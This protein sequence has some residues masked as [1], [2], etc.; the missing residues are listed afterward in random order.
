MCKNVN[1]K[2]Q[3]KLARL[4]LCHNNFIQFHVTLINTFIR[5]YIVLLL[6]RSS[7]QFGMYLVMKQLFKSLPDGNMYMLPAGMYTAMYSIHVPHVISLVWCWYLYFGQNQHRA[8]KYHAVHSIVLCIAQNYR[9]LH[10][11]NLLDKFFACH[12]FCLEE[13]E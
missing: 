13:E 1:S 7:H 9:D 5:R 3:P 8:K 11:G 10:F 12:V 2:Q 4:I 6:H